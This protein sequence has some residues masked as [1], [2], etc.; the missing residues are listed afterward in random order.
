M[1]EKKNTDY[2]AS[3][4]NLCNPVELKVKIEQRQNLTR[5][6]NHLNA[7]LTTY[8]EWAELRG[9]EQA[10]TDCD[11]TIRE[12]IDQ[13]GSYQDVEAGEYALKQR[14]ESIIYKPELTK[15][16]LDA[17]FTS[18]VIVET[19]DSKAL[20]GLVKGGLVTP[21]QARECGEVKE[22]FAYIIK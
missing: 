13:L 22:S 8:P 2:S 12:A 11:K 14:R 4:V 3:A 19:V 6:A 5:Q 16:V 9:V 17:K 18:L 1:A 15:L 21:L 10:L 7:L 20:D